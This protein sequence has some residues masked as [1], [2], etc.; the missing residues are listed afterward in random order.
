MIFTIIFLLLKT[1]SIAFHSF[2]T[3]KSQYMNSIK[4]VNLH[5]HHNHHHH[6]QHHNLILKR[7]TPTINTK[8]NLFNLLHTNMPISVAIVTAL[9]LP[10]NAWS[11]TLSI[12]SSSLSLSLSS[13][14]SSLSIADGLD[15]E[16]LGALGDVQDL[17]DALNDAIDVSN[18]T[19]DILTKLVDSP[20][21]LVIP[22]GAGLLVASGVGFLIYS[23]GKVNE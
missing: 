20:L 12:A 21:I 7:S 10:L 6:N 4:T 1:Q 8:L 18:P 3:T 19:A 16:T 9:S 15:A 2:H 13:L 14:S 17:T 22:I 23:Y 11:S 5:H